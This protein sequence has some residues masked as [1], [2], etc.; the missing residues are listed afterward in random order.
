M[1]VQLLMSSKPV[2]AGA[3]SECGGWEQ[4]QGCHSAFIHPCSEIWSVGMGQ[5][6]GDQLEQPLD[7]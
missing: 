3:P 4:G 5:V 7:V 6:L 1:A 2:D